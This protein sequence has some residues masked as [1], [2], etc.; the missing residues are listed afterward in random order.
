MLIVRCRKKAE[1]VETRRCDVSYG[2]LRF[3][4]AC[5]QALVT[6]R[7]AMG[8]ESRRSSCLDRS[9]TASN[10]IVQMKVLVYFI[11]DV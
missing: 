1:K 4:E 3:V 7:F 11:N 9:S 5:G 10:Y 2:S 6:G 8:S